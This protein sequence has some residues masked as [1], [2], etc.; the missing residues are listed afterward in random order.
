MFPAG[1]HHGCDADLL[2]TTIKGDH[3]RTMMTKFGSN[4]SRG[5]RGEGLW[6]KS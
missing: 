5:F 1:G 2:D 4:W 3:P 6:L